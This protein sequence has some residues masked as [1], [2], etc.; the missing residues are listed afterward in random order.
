MFEEI[1]NTKSTTKIRN[2]RSDFPLLSEIIN[3]HPLV[4]FDN[5][6]TTQKPSAVIDAITNYYA[7]SNSNVHRGVHSL[8][9]K[10]TELYEV[11]RTRT[12]QFI[13]AG[14]SE[15]IIFTKGTTEALNLLAH[16]L[17]SLLLAEGDEI[18][19]TEME[20]HSNFVPWQVIAGEKG[21]SLKVA[22]INDKGELSLEEL[23]SLFSDKTKILAITH[24]SNTLGSINDIKKIS[25][26]AHQKGIVV[27]VDGA[28]YIPHKPVDVQDLDCDFYV[29]SAHK[30]FGPTGIGVMFG[31][32]NLLSDMPPYQLGGGMIQD[33]TIEET[34]YTKPPQIFE[35]GTPNI[36]GAVGMTAAMDYI[37]DVG[38]DFIVQHED[39]LLNYA[40]EKLNMIDA[41][42]FIG[43]A[44]DKVSLI[45]F[46]IKGHH[47]FDVGSLLDQTGIA[48][49]TGHHCTQPIMT[50][51][52]IT[53]TVR[54]SFAFYNT[55]E[56]ID[57]FIES[58]QRVIK[59]LN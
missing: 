23:E 1:K 40:S 24:A 53:G 20:H 4:Y 12:K 38:Y 25:H 9:Q 21:A 52:N 32:Y 45:S 6:A 10:A 8:S 22:S 28:Q 56:E 3:D 41:V 17:G 46:N 51:Y 13:N 15:E 55:F 27:V 54:V 44:D 19:I 37:T 35:A 31:K 34:S 2:I 50:H 39:A 36:A 7:H 43:K 11:A 57:A 29:F 16:S 47:P 58:L 18:I 33:V 49:R 26:I 14:K 59:I 42:E 5:A 48:V 30:L